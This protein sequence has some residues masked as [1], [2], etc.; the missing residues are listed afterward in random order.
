M[1]EPVDNET[2]RR[3][4]RL[5]QRVRDQ[6]AEAGLPVTADLDMRFAVGAEVR[7]D[8]APDDI[9]GVYVG[10]R[11]HPA[12]SARIREVMLS[13]DVTDPV[14]RRAGEVSRAMLEAIGRILAAGGFTVGPSRNDMSPQTLHVTGAPDRAA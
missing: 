14:V 6:L 4:E 12:L 7:I 9:G 1:A 5:A 8:P 11:S 2:L 3:M 13:G 10:W